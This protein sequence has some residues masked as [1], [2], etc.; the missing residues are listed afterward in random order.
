MV[1]V[2]CVS[3]SKLRCIYCSIPTGADIA[4]VSERSCSRVDRKILGA[5]RGY[6]RI[7]IHIDKSLE[8]T[9]KAKPRDVS[10]RPVLSAT[11]ENDGRQS[12]GRSPSKNG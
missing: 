1:A 9:L 8:A 6:P 7:I 10:V 2:V 12:G 5:N 11:S 3:G 4:R